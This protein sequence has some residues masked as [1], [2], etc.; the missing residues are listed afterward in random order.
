MS[1]R[2]INPPFSLLCGHISIILY[3]TSLIYIPHFVLLLS[4]SSPILGDDFF[5][6][7]YLSMYDEEKKTK[8]KKKKNKEK[9]KKERKRK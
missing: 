2:L 7:V 6:R 8:K 5:L 1:H 9:K 4:R 3:H